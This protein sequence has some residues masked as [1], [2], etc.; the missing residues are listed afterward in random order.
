MGV[1]GGGCETMRYA[2]P[3]LE[4]VFSIRLQGETLPSDLIDPPVVR[5]GPH[6]PWKGFLCLHPVELLVIEKGNSKHPTS[7]PRREPW[8]EMVD[9]TPPT[10]QPKVVIEAWRSDPNLW[11]Y[12]PMSMSVTT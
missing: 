10:T 3:K 7:S 8:E 12:G 6:R 4:L 1:L 2:W 9:S 5:L 11:K